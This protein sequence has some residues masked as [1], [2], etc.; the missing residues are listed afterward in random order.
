MRMRP[1]IL[2]FNRAQGSGENMSLG[3]SD[4]FILIHEMGHAIGFKHPGDYNAGGVKRSA[5][6][7]C[8]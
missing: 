2:G 3:Q 5:D 1:H 6:H 4:F 7:L 8:K